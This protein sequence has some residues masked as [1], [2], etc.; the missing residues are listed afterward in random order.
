M[1]DVRY[2]IVSLYDREQSV[3]I[4]VYREGELQVSGSY[5]DYKET[6]SCRRRSRDPEDDLNWMPSLPLSSR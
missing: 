5:S 6:N 4:Y 3:V 1:P 2:G